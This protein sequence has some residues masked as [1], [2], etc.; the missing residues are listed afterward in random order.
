MSNRFWSF[1]DRGQACAD[2]FE[3]G[4]EMMIVLV[5]ILSMGKDEDMMR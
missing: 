5:M 3:H 1:H 2:S 4:H